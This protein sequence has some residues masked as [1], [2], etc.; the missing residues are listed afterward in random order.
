MEKHHPR[1]DAAPGMEEFTVQGYNG[2]DLTFTGRL[3]SEGSF[4]DD[5][6]GSLTRLRLFTMGG[7]RLVYSVVSGAG[8]HKDRRVYV[9]KVDKENCQIDNG[10]Q[11]IEMPV[12][13]LFTAVFGLCGLE[14]GQES[15][16][17]A[18]LEES[19]QAVSA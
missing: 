9:L 18:A 16:L 8:K 7:N 3:F 5:E 17:R 1:Q 11:H 14:A 15:D 19:L 13:M 2:G 12:E 10:Q 6:S 4:F